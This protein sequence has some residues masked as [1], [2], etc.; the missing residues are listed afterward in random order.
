MIRKLIYL[1]AAVLSTGA[2][3]QSGWG[4]G[5]LNLTLEEAL[6]RAPEANFEILIGEEALIRQQQAQRR[7]R[8]ELLPQISGEVSQQRSQSYFNL[9]EQLRGTSITNRFDALLRAS[10][11]I[12][13]A[14]TIADYRLERI[15]TEIARLSLRSTVQDILQAIAETYFTH[16]RNVRREETIQADIERD[17]ALL[18]LA[19][20]R[21]NAGA[22]TE[23][24][25]TR[26]EV[27]LASN[28]LRLAQQETLVE[29]SALELKRSLNFD[30]GRELELHRTELQEL[31][32][33][34]YKPG[35]LQAI[36]DQRPE[37]VR[38]VRTLERNKL[39]RRAATLE[40]LPSLDLTGTYGYAA[41]TYEDDM[42]EV[43]SVGIGLNVPI[44]EGFRINANRRE[45]ASAVRQQETV[46]R[47][48]E[49][50]VEAN[51][52]LVL[53]QLRSTRQQVEIAR[54]QVSLAERELELARVRFE[55][56]VADNSEVVEAQASVAQAADGLVEAEYQ[57]HLARLALA[58]VRG[59][60]RSILSST[61]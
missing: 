58:R 49:T 54:Q 52:R 53:S 12:F 59:D 60:V 15:N 48:V 19:R 16:L 23:I 45:A 6:D 34:V 28:R 29:Q 27:A 36:L 20:N 40:R 11:T 47:Q 8:A 13:D 51:Y 37:V 17:Q 39:A 14:S 10:F 2:L 44:F 30:L 56:G 46:V 9:D 57:L 41:E 35:E 1:F 55:E 61:N 5:T 31:G 18:E 32:E 33:V 3:P 21:F 24:D 42:E 38:E 50:Q 25:V 7:A 43:W 26:G 22:A 4:Q